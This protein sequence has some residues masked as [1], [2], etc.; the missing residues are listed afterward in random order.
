MIGENDQNRK[1]KSGSF[2]RLLAEV[3]IIIRKNQHQAMS[4]KPKRQSELGAASGS[5]GSMISPF[6]IAA[7]EVALTE[8]S[9]EKIFVEQQ[10]NVSDTPM[11]ST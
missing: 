1:I 3:H 9:H 7:R 4:G 10:S 6:D 11:D 8:Q 2:L 5:R